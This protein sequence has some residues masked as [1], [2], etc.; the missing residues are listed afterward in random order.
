MAASFAEINCNQEKPS[1]IHTN[2]IRNLSGLM[3]DRENTAFDLMDELNGRAYVNSSKNAEARWSIG[4][5]ST[6]RTAST[7]PLFPP[8][9]RPSRLIFPP[10][11]HVTRRPG[12]VPRTF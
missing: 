10:G 7:T 11:R 3:S 2:A 6:C 8:G 5:K 1:A 4:S 12:T 9:W